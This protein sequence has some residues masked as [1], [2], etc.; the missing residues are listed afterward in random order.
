MRR[1]G[2]GE[3][4]WSLFWVIVNP[5]LAFVPKLTGI[6]AILRLF[7]GRAGFSVVCVCVCV[8]SMYGLQQKR[9]IAKCWR[10][11]NHGG[12]KRARTRVGREFAYESSFVAEAVEQKKNQAKYKDDVDSGVWGSPCRRSFQ[13]AQSIKAFMQGVL[14]FP[15]I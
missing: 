13:V 7:R 15:G 4:S 10:M 8:Q 14:S 3:T 11:M 1:R 9:Q 5:D 6:A 2:S 12:R